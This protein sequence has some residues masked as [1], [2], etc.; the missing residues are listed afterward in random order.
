MV[1]LFVYICSG[2]NFDDLGRLLNESWLIKKTFSNKVSN[3]NI[4][5]LYNDGL[6]AGAIGG[7]L[8]GAG[9][10]GFILFYC[11]RDKQKNLIS[12]FKKF[13]HVPFE[14]KNE[15]SVIINN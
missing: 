5:S 2:K 1:L 8:L 4:D 12:K 10:S 6:K 9:K 15:G 13:V 14:F 3:K 11:E 7:K